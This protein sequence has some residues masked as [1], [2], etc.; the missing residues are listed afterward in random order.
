MGDG[1][2]LLRLFLETISDREAPKKDLWAH[3][4]RVRQELKKYLEGDFSYHIK[5]TNKSLMDTLK[6]FDR[7]EFQKKGNRVKTWFKELGQKITIFFTSPA[8]IV[9]QGFFKQI[10]VNSL[11]QKTLSGEKVRHNLLF[12]CYFPIFIYFFCCVN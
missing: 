7:H 10:D 11:H 3:C 5:P 6:S 8:S 4:T 12:V 2:A 1:V 9:Y